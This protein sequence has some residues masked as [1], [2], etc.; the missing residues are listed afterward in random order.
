[1]ELELSTRIVSA[2]ESEKRFVKLEQK[3]LQNDKEKSNYIVSMLA[4]LNQGN[5]TVSQNDNTPASDISDKALNSDMTQETKTQLEIYN[6]RISNEIREINREKKLLQSDEASNS[7]NSGLSSDISSEIKIKMKTPEIDIQPLVQEL[8]LELSEA[9]TEETGLDP[10]V[11]PESSRIEK[12]TDDHIL[13]DSLP[14]TQIVAP[15]KIYTS[16]ISKIDPNKNR[17]YQYA[18]EHG[19]NP[20]EFS[21]ITEAEKNRWTMECFHRERLVGE[22]L[23][24]QAIL[25]SG[26][27]TAWLDDLMEKIHAQFTQISFEEKTLFVLWVNIQSTPSKRQ[28]PIS[29][30]PSNPEEMQQ[31]VINMVV[32]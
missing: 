24:R 8:F 23:L 6:E 12:D 19:I 21:I 22:E 9:H 18:I 26:L 20:K 13:Q 3:Q 1:M 16:S 29:V 5:Q 30:L 27:S 32:E 7:Q 4:Q 17:L 14:E 10:W 11:K 31:H 15:N 25:K 2:K 28:F